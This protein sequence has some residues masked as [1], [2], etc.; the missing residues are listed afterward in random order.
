VRILGIDPGYA[1]VGWAILESDFKPNDIVF[2]ECGVISTSEKIDFN[3]RLQ[4]IYD[5]IN[6]L[7]V[8]FQ[9]GYCGME[10]LMFQNNAKTAMKVSEARGVINL[11]FH[12]ANLP[13]KSVTPL[14]VKNSI[15]GYGK[16]DKKQVQE[17]VRMIC[18]LDEIPQPD[19]AADAVAVAISAL[20]FIKNERLLK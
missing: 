12:Q 17:S 1:L 5:D 19:D 9:P 13:V 4:E 18:N 7:I 11:A 14:Q 10:T 16:A 2:V 8:E 15:T 6:Q 3:Q 20:D